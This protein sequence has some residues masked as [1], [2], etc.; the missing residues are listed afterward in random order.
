M[1]ML[2][3]NETQVYTQN[4]FPVKC[5]GFKTNDKGQWTCKNCHTVYISLIIV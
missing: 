1:E 4:N 3:N 5:H 2:E